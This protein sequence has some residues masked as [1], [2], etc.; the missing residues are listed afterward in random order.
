MGASLTNVQVYVGRFSPG[1]A[2]STVVAAVCQ[3]L[4]GGTWAGVGRQPRER[5]Q[6]VVVG[7]AGREPWISV[8][9]E[10]PAW[11]AGRLARLAAGLSAM[12]GITAVGVRVCDGDLLELR[13]YHRGALFDTYCNEAEGR[14]ATA[15]PGGWGRPERWA[16]L[17]APVGALNKLR[18]VWAEGPLFAEQTLFRT[19]Q[20]LGMDAERAGLGLDD[21]DVE[22]PGSDELLSGAL[23]L[24]LP[25]PLQLPYQAATATLAARATLRR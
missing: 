5:E 12:L 20:L 22:R 10:T 19:A 14:A 6:L 3:L 9:D 17:L 18:A 15:R 7:P 2:Q 25:P 4:Q 24:R 23:I 11:E 8:Y 16:D 13:R 1:K 21:L